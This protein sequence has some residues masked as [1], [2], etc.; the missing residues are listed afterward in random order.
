M[1]FLYPQTQHALIPQTGQAAKNENIALAR[2]TSA[3]RAEFFQLLNDKIEEI[4]PNYD[5]VTNNNQL[6][7]QIRPILDTDNRIK[8]AHQRR[9]Q[10]QDRLWQRIISDIAEDSNRLTQEFSTYQKLSNQ[11]AL[12]LNPELEYPSHQLKRDIHRMPGGYLQNRD[13][14]DFW[15]GAVYDHGFF[16][17]GQ[18]WFGGLNDEL[19]HTLINNVLGKYYPQFTPQT[20]LDMGCSV[21]HS[22]LPYTEA[23]PQAKVYGIDLGP[24]LLRYASARAR[25]F[26]QKVYFYQQNAE[27]T[28]FSANSFDLVVSHILL[29]EIPAGARKRVLAESYRLLKPGGV[30]IHLESQLFLSPPSLVA[31]Y[32]RDTEVWVNSEPYLASSKLEDLKNYA[33]SAGF[34]TQEFKIQRVA[35]HFAQ[36]RGNNNPGWLAIGARKL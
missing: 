11:G 2:E 5:N 30:M 31:R 24:A 14:N 8:L 20:I 7:S 27:K 10:L 21:G 4:L 36:Q 12:E 34:A 6:Y 25:T 22:T 15:T 1:V 26:P 19:G 13:E 17:Y 16:F 32:F 35:G 29:H 28:D 18:G 23:Y 33:L 9:S 3:F